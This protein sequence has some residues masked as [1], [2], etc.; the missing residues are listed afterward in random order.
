MYLRDDTNYDSR[1]KSIP[2]LML[3]PPLQTT[4]KSE[5]DSQFDHLQFFTELNFDIYQI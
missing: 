5:T 3:G 2:N 4:I 1:L